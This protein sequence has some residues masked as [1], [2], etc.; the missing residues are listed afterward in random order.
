MPTPATTR[1]H[2][3]AATLNSFT[4]VCGKVCRCY[5]LL[6]LA[7]QFPN[8]RRF[9]VSMRIALEGELQHLHWQFRR[10]EARTQCGHQPERPGLRGS[11]AGRS[12]G[13]NIYHGLDQQQNYVRIASEAG[14]LWERIK[15]VAGT[16]YGWPKS[17]Y[18]AEPPFFSTFT[19]KTEATKAINT[20]AIDLKSPEPV[21]DAALRP[22]S[23]ARLVITLSDCS[24]TAV[25]V[26]L[27]H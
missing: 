6:R 2:A 26:L 9:P 17:T 12:G 27:R 3:F 13:N 23:D 7:G 18:I 15:G 22:Q 1:P 4:T 25:T 5:S 8:L 20:G 19:M 16:T 21:P 24:R 14:E 10:P 11:V